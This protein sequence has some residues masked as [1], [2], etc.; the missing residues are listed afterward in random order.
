MLDSITSK[1]YLHAKAKKSVMK[2]GT[3]VKG[4]HC[5][6][7]L[8]KFCLKYRSCR[9]RRFFSPNMKGEPFVSFKF[10]FDTFRLGS[11]R[12]SRPTIES[13]LYTYHVSILVMSSGAL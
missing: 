12:G 13:N 3:T 9:R 5:R 11:L 10:G 7:T 2:G 6:K 1:C 4:M 8:V